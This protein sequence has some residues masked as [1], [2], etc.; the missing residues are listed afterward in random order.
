MIIK[1]MDKSKF[2][3][4]GKY[5]SKC[6]S[7]KFISLYIAKWEINL[8]E[9]QLYQLRSNKVYYIMNIE[10]VDKI[11]DSYVEYKSSGKTLSEY[12]ERSDVEETESDSSG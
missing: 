9:L 7:H 11:N 8:D 5:V 4:E 2:V 1:C 6:I 10:I 3:F 12:F